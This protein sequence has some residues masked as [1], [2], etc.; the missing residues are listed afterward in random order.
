MKKELFSSLFVS[1]TKM[2]KQIMICFFQFS[3]LCLNEKW[4]KKRI[5]D[6]YVTSM[7]VMPDF[8]AAYGLI[9]VQDQTETRP[10]PDQDQGG[11]QASAGFESQLR[12]PALP[13]ALSLWSGSG[14]VLVS[15]P[16]WSRSGP[17]LISTLVPVWSQSH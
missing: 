2:K 10:G 5:T 16:R 4:K 13:W 12:A 1:K 3:I 8:C 17:S 15:G 11:L 7:T 9:Q 6:V 14:L